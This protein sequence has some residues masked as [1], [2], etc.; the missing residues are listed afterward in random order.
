M[1]SKPKENELVDIDIDPAEPFSK[2][3]HRY[4]SK[5]RKSKAMSEFK[6][7]V[8]EEPITNQD[9][10]KEQTN[11]ATSMGEQENKIVDDKNIVDLL[12]ETINNSSITDNVSI[13]LDNKTK[14]CLIF[15]LE[16]YPNELDGFDRLIKMA[17]KNCKIDINDLHIIIALCSKIQ[18]LV[19][20]TN[21]DF[22]TSI[23]CSRMVLKFIIR[24]L[25]I[26]KKIKIEDEQIETYLKAVD[27]LVDVCLDMLLESKNVEKGCN[28]FF[29][30]LLCKKK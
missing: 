22:K 15:I 16:T 20:K 13:K 18:S 8:S 26:E 21:L 4:R 23:E 2:K 19:S 12:K 17:I 25:I 10:P 30:K 5:P 14:E 1:D 24:V 6:K 7:S 27:N 29:K 28:S 3:K 9:E 11:K